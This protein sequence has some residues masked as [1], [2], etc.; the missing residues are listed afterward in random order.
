MTLQDGVACRWSLNVTREH[1][2]VS[3]S[4]SDLGEFGRSV[5]TEISSILISGFYDIGLV[6]MLMH[7]C[8]C[9]RWQPCLF[10]REQDKKSD[11][12]YSTSLEFE[13][14][15]TWRI[16]RSW[17][18]NSEHGEEWSWI[19]NASQYFFLP[20]TCAFGHRQ[21]QI[22]SVHCK[23]ELARQTHAAQIGDNW[24]WA[25]SSM[26]FC[27]CSCK[28]AFSFLKACTRSDNLKLTSP[29]RSADLR[30]FDHASSSAS[31]SSISGRGSNAATTWG[32]FETFV[33][34]ENLDSEC[35]E[36]SR[37]CW[38]SDRTA[39]Q[40]SALSRARDK[41]C[42]IFESNSMHATRVEDW[43]VSR[44]EGLACS[45]KWGQFN[46]Y[47]S[48]AKFVASREGNQTDI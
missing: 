15:L 36:A 27:T 42:C 7:L 19:S 6:G 48:P 35:N 5:R 30:A 33:A 23:L 14:K 44:S 12:E 21:Y 34:C 9:F 11:C 13:D 4:S 39:S 45:R 43:S 46:F 24:T 37:A 25:R 26:L 29:A 10:P 38:H 28:A 8:T 31:I 20:V 32:L 3:M 18:C 40:I 17:G 2:S 16:R 22:Q 47:I 1:C 41:S